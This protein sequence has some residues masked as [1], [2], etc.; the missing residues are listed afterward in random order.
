VRT[1]PK[2]QSVEVIARSALMRAHENMRDADDREHVTKYLYRNP[3]QFVIRDFRYAS[4]CGTVP[5]AVDTL[6]DF[7]RVEACLRTMGKAPWNATL[8][9]MLRVF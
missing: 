3:E 7:T 8:E 5:M 1:Y 6:E 2:G 9:A 4:D